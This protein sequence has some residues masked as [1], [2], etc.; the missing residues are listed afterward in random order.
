MPNLQF[1]IS[2]SPSSKYCG[3]QS[4]H[5][6]MVKGLS[7]FW[8]AA[9][10]IFLCQVYLQ[11]YYTLIRFSTIESHN[12]VLVLRM[13]H[14]KWNEIKQTPSMLPFR[15]VSGCCLVSFI[16]CGPSWARALYILWSRKRV[17]AC[18][19]WPPN[20]LAEGTLCHQPHTAAFNGFPIKVWTVRR[21]FQNTLM[22]ME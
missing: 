6:R 4:G 15:A 7:N 22:P 12:T 8:L 17:N 9:T 13:A 20:Y 21:A 5:N 16:S 18:E 19:I 14:R 2:D 11:L 10:R 3:Q 1:L